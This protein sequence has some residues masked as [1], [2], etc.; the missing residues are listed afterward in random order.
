MPDQVEAQSQYLAT[1][2]AG[3]QEF[4]AAT[5]FQ[6]QGKK[7]FNMVHALCIPPVYAQPVAPDDGAFEL[8]ISPAVDGLV[9][10]HNCSMMD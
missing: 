7:N 6:I 2:I 1:I 4:L 9:V 8:A 5:G 10:S 3:M